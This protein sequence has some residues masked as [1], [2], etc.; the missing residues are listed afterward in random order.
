MQVYISH[1]REAKLRSYSKLQGK[2]LSSLIAEF[3]DNLNHA[4]VPVVENVEKP[5]TDLKPMCDKQF[6]KTRSENKYIIIA[7]D[8]QTELTMNL[9]TFHWHQARREGEGREIE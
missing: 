2:T 7:D 9:C 5:V 1:E 3:I 4:F 8:G 6:C